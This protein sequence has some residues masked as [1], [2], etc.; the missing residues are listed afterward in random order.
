MKC[1]RKTYFVAA[2]ALA[3]LFAALL[4]GVRT[5]DVRPIGPMGSTVGLAAVNER[6]F[7]GTGVHLFW[8][9]LTDWL[10]VAAVLTA[11]GFAV[12]GLV[13]LI[14]RRSFF[15]VDGSLYALAVVYLLT[16]GCY[17]LFELWIVNYRPVL[18][19]GRLE[20]SFPSSHTMI[21]CTIMATAMMEFRTR[22]K[23]KT[24]RAAVQAL[25]AGLML[26]T[27]AGRLISGVH[28]FTDILGGLLLSGALTMLYAGRRPRTL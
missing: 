10:G 14:R 20:A 13:Q 7:A 27:V 26:V 23:N 28:W 18:M 17:I 15:K 21:V 19:Q 16:V 24:V 22:L 11:L 3:L 8:Y 6:V 2:A 9:T 4:T 1:S 25:C 12:L 5:L